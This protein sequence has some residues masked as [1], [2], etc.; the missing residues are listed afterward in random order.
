MKP[1]T[2]TLKKVF[3][4]HGE[5]P[6]ANALAADVKAEYG[7]HTLIAAPDARFDLSSNA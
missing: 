7:I 2:P 1:M 5:A 3:L 4:V 6:E